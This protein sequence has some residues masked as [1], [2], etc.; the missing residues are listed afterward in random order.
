MSLISCLLELRKPLALLGILLFCASPALAQG[1]TDFVTTNTSAGAFPL[2]DQSAAFIVVETNA[3]PGVSLAAGSLATDLLR[4]TGAKP[5]I[6]S[7]PARAGR[8][9]VIIGTLGRSALVDAL[10]RA[11]KIDV[12]AIS[13]KWESFL[14]QV[15][16]K[17]FR[18][19]DRALVVCG[20]DKRGTIYGIYEISRQIGV[21]PWY[22]WADV[23]PQHHTQ[24]FVRAGT[25]RQGPPSVKYRGFFLNDEAPDLSNWITEKYGAVPG[26][27][28][29]AN[30]GCGFYTNLFEVLLRLRGNYLWPAMWNNAFNEDDPENPRLADE[31]GIVM[32]TS[33]QEP[34]LRAQKEWD[35]GLGK[36]HGNWNYSQTNQQPVLQQFWREGIRRNKNFES[37]VTLGLRA[38]NDSGAELGKDLTERIIG[39]Q[40]SI[41]AEEVNPDLAKV[42][43]LWCLYKEV[44]GY[45]S[46]GLR[47][48]DDVTLLWAED[49]WGDVRRLPSAAERQRSGGAGIYYHFDYHGSPRNYQW[50][51]T[52]PLPK[53]WDQ[54]SLAKQYGAD[55]IWIVNAG[56][57]KGCE[58]PLAFFLNFAWD[59]SRWS[60]DNLDDYARQW[61]RE[62]FGPEHAA[63][64]ADIISTYTQFNGRRKPELL[65]PNVYSLVN[66]NEFE[67]V[68]ADYAALAAKAELLEQQ[69]PS[70]SRDAFAELVWFPT[71]AAAGLNA[72]YLA[73]ARNLLHAEQ[74]RASA[75]D[76]AARARALFVEQTN[77]MGWFNHTLA[78]GKWSHFMDQPYIGYRNWNEPHSNNLDAIGLR[79]VEVPDAAALGVAV[80]GSETAVTNGDIALPCFD[81]FNQQRRYVDVFNQG[82]TPFSFSVTASAP[83]IQVSKSAGRVEQ[84]ERLWVSIDW[85]KAPAGNGTG[86]LRISGTGRQ[87][88]VKITAFNPVAPTRTAVQ[89]FVEGDGCV[90]IEAEH[91]TPNVPAGANRWIPIP[92]YGHTLSAMRADGPV[93]VLASPGKDSP[94]LEYQMYLFTPG[95]VEVDAI[96]GPTLNFL[97]G[98]PLRYA[99]SFDDAEPQVITI[100]PADYNAGKGNRDWETA[101]TDNCRHAKSQH[102]L[103]APGYHT[104]KIWMVD[105]AV[106]VEKI[107]VNTGGVRPSYLG[108]PE[109]FH[110]ARNLYRYGERLSPDAV[111]SKFQ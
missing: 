75:N 49:N 81:V 1:E 79:D 99:V 69:L 43:Q 31:Y 66:Y 25:F 57:F 90:S 28:N 102:T 100:V 84:D 92:H 11:G 85:S 37:I 36:I 46:E 20:S 39:V 60:N 89:G 76:Y 44:Q 42:P 93:D 72:M 51:N 77:L 96:V 67:K 103:T 110:G 15:V 50:I 106:A 105:P 70:Q 62:N 52:S 12:S 98:R 41:L 88:A 13:G 33:H 8:Y 32:G 2:F 94:C 86:E 97:P 16:R 65:W 29:V 23:P 91:F 111:R 14:V 10:I 78:D 4:V 35:R 48:P 45:Y 9:P 27:T 34:M 58:F 47:V 61:A 24:L 108:P 7:S 53:I 17:P 73:A 64:I 26:R 71:K 82:K 54:L 95:P 87:V 74:G 30:Y 6:C 5:A 63:E 83:W 56:H 3:W 21:S 18:G 104:L 101:V 40:R 80:D 109:S 38:E 55:R 107:V 68:V 22:W 19:V 59:T